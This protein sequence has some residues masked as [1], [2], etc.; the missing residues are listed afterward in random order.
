MEAPDQTVSKNASSTRGSG[1][2][3]QLKKKQ[4]LGC[5]QGEACKHDQTSKNK[6]TKMEAKL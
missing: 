5:F 1:V 2:I 6:R 3:C 4:R